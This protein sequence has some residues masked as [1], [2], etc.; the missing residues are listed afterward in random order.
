MCSTEWTTCIIYLSRFPF[1]VIILCYVNFKNWNIPSILIWVL[2]QVWV[3][4]TAHNNQ[5]KKIRSNQA[6]TGV[7]ST[8]SGRVCPTKHVVPECG[9]IGVFDLCFAEI[10]HF[11]EFNVLIRSVSACFLKRHLECVVWQC[12]TSHLLELKVGPTFT[13][14]LVKG[15][16]L[17][18]CHHSKHITLACM[19]KGCCFS[20]SCGSQVHKP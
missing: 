10:F 1:I 4:F 5:I 19:L 14:A 12:A 11:L 6:S 15:L 16:Y 9:F 2:N 13:G 8:L 3:H 7:F 17:V 18:S 20:V